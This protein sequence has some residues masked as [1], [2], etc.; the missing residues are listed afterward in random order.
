TQ[1]ET[2]SEV[3]TVIQHSVDA[4]EEKRQWYIEH[5]E[6]VFN[7]SLKPHELS[8]Y[9]N[10]S[11]WLQTLQTQ[12]E[13][14][15]FTSEEIKK[16]CLF[17]QCYIVEVD[18]RH[19]NYL[20]LAQ[21][22]DLRKNIFIGVGSRLSEKCQEILNQCQSVT[23]EWLVEPKTIEELLQLK[24]SIQAYFQI[25]KKKLHHQCA[26]LQNYLQFFLKND[27][28]SI[29]LLRKLQR[30]SKC[31]EAMNQT[32]LKEAQQTLQKTERE[33]IEHIQLKINTLFEK[34]IPKYVD[35]FNAI[36]TEFNHI[37]S[38]KNPNKLTHL[39]T[40]YEDIV[41]EEQTV[42]HDAQALQIEDSFDTTL[43]QQWN[44]TKE[45]T[46]KLLKIWETA[47]SFQRQYHDWL[48]NNPFEMN[49]NNVENAYN[50][51][52]A[53][54]A[55]LLT[56]NKDSQLLTQIQHQLQ[57]FKEDSSLLLLQILSNKK[58][59]EKD[60]KSISAI[61]GFD[62]SPMVTSLNLEYLMERRVF[63]Y[64]QQLA[65]FVTPSN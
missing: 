30:V 36:K 61:V 15:Q 3:Q 65:H 37:D 4:L 13:Q 50:Q 42:S 48:K 54:I 49:Y 60:W 10:E 52:V 40:M 8:S 45:E 14:L 35:K 2:I 39:V 20:I 12:L 57:V 22:Q 29:D 58:L 43:L 19:I 63:K 47:Q 25:H 26:S 34:L 11:L 7:I 32:H 62:I 55:T 17:F 31:Y 21:V 64:A 38:L 9:E 24:N 28:I 27:Y 33:I 5:Y 46:Q 16:T 56:I 59:H 18:C 51:L 53:Q 23:K 6:H 44:I 41:R 1:M